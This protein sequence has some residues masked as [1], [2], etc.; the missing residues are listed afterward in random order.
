M[1]LA[2]DIPSGQHFIQTDL[3]NN[4]DFE[5]E[6]TEDI[7]D[8][9]PVYSN[10]NNIVKSK[11]RKALD[12]RDALYQSAKNII[13]NNHNVKTQESFGKYVAAELKSLPPLKRN[14]LKLNFQQLI[15][16]IKHDIDCPLTE[17]IK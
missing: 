8:E 9:R 7:E 13:K 12:Y 6:P 17:L 10:N 15:M 1:K 4:H 11:K 14:L 16:K 2:N 3:G 5:C